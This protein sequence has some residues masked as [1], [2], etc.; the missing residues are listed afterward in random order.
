MGQSDVVALAHFFWGRAES[1]NKVY[2]RGLG[3][4]R[5]SSKPVRER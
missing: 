4:C 1:E 3:W 5:E 2:N